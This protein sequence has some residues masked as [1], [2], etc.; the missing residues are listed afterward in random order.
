MSH[1]PCE[2]GEAKMGVG[3]GGVGRMYRH[4]YKG[5]KDDLD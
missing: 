1:L 5:L 4:L 3:W 2:V